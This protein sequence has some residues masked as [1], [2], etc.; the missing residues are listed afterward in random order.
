MKHLSL[1]LFSV[2]TLKLFI[3]LAFC[4]VNWLRYRSVRLGS[5]KSKPGPGEGCSLVD[6]FPLLVAVS[7]F[8]L[9]RQLL[10]IELCNSN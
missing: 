4:K 9:L 1:R 7:S 3:Y 2:A 8:S 5:M 6:S 10:L